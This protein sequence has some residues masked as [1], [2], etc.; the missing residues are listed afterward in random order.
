M[1]FLIVAR[2]FDTS[3]FCWAM[4]GLLVRLAN[5][6]GLHRDGSLFDMTP[7][8]I[9][10]RR[11]V[12]WS[13]VKVD[14]RSSEELGMELTIQ[15]RTFDTEV[16]LNINDADMSPE[17]TTPL[18][19]K[20]GPTDMSVHLLRC[21]ITKI[22]RR[23]IGTVAAGCLAPPTDGGEAL[24]ATLEDLEGSLI[25]TH[26][27]H[28]QEIIRQHTS[29]DD[30]DDAMSWMVRIIT[31]IVM[32]KMSLTI[33]Q[34]IL[35]TEPDK[36]RPEI[37]QRIYVSAL[38]ILES[39]TRLHRDARKH[40]FRWLFMTYS[41]WQPLAYVLIESARRSW[42][43]LTERAWE[44]VCGFQRI[45]LEKTK[46]ADQAAVFLPLRKLFLCVRRH[47]AIELARLRKDL[48]EAK[49]LVQEEET[50]MTAP[51]FGQFRETQDGMAQAREKWWRLLKPGDNASLPAPL[52]RPDQFF[53]S[54]QQQPAAELRGSPPSV[55]SGT[56]QRDIVSMSD[57]QMQFMNQ[58]MSQPASSVAD[59]Y[60]LDAPGFMGVVMSDIG[61]SGPGGMDSQS[62]S[63]PGPAAPSSGSSTAVPGASVAT[64]SIGTESM[65]SEQIS[66][67]QIMQANDQLPSFMWGNWFNESAAGGTGQGGVQDKSMDDTI[68]PE[69]LNM[70]DQD[71]DWQ[72]WTQTLKGVDMWQGEAPGAR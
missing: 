55:A 27:A 14:L 59:L 65:F 24:A 32:A 20:S 2:R 64:T 16:P 38:E 41:T 13:I 10:M 33:Y 53:A 66:P 71:F 5:G 9:E 8:E 37:R 52:A 44:A 49:R 12:W 29:G 58:F 43:P 72:D 56:G 34:P 50:N 4:T 69:D 17:G 36:L 3:R 68:A 35:F 51:W 47:R 63:F 30:A 26:F 60:A 39:D 22:A 54:P 61:G 15:D 23:V 67:H 57:A 21:E 11:R 48:G 28:M 31:R 40:P 7:F 25:S 1:I 46:N 42:T 45:P 19:A 18:V 62:M 6:M 70:L